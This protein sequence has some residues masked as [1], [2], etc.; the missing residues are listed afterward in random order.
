MAIILPGPLVGEIRGS[1]GGTTFSRNRHGQYTRQRSVPVNPNTQRQADARER[2]NTLAT[3]WRDVLSQANRDG[4]DL[5]GAN[6]N[7]INGV[8]QV[9]K[10]TGMNHFI[11]SNAGRL[12]TSQP[13]IDAF[14]TEYGLPDQEV[15]WSFA[16][17][18]ATQQITLTYTFASDV[19]DQVYVFHMGM[20]VSGSRVFFA[21]P[22]RYWHRVIGDSGSPPASPLVGVIPY[23]VSA[24]NRVFL[25][26]R[27]HDADN[28]LTEP[29]RRNV[30]VT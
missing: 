12:L 11:R 4:W 13:V 20:P 23:P 2:F 24:G 15:L 16:V 9:T 19:D 27:R 8:G 6:T 29:F 7:W 14:P 21:G 30:I 28:R 3:Y 18:S 5:Y 17:D 22:W 10:L 25:Y 26:C 1:M